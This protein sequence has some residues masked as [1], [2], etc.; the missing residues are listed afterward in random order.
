MSVSDSHVEPHYTMSHQYAF[1]T[2]FLGLFAPRVGQQYRDEQRRRRSQ[3]DRGTT[4]AEREAFW[5]RTINPRRVTGTGNNVRGGTSFIDSGM[6]Q[7]YETQ[8]T[9]EGPSSS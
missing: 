3:F 6:K 9:T 5:V 1:L 2:P 7:W 4:A 8:P